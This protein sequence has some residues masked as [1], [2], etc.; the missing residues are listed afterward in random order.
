MKTLTCNCCGGQIDKE[1]MTCKS[2]G[3]TYLQTSG[4]IITVNIEVGDMPLCEVNH[5]IKGIR[6]IIES[7]KVIKEDECVIYNVTRNGVGKITIDT[8]ALTKE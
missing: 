2:C 3:T 6:D 1:T 5:R 7:S 4:K 8:V